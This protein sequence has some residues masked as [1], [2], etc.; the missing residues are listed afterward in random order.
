MLCLHPVVVFTCQGRGLLVPCRV[1]SIL[2]LSHAYIVQVLFFF[3][4]DIVGI[5]K[6]SFVLYLLF[7]FVLSYQFIINHHMQ[8]T[9]K[10]SLL[11]FDSFK[12]CVRMLLVFLF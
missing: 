12:I 2:V 10:L 7:F 4:V 3:L 11:N 6:V 8:A 5:S 1:S 9:L